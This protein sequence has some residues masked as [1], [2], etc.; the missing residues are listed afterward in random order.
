ML[1][2]HIRNAN[3]TDASIL[4]D[5]IRLSFI[6]VAWRFGLTPDKCPKHPSNCTDAWIEN[7]FARGVT[8]YIFENENAAIGCVALE[9]AD[10]DLCY[11]ERLSVLPAKRRKGFGRAL[12]DHVIHQANL[13]GAKQIGIGIIADDTELKQWYQKIGFV[14]GDTKE[15]EHLPFRVQFMHYQL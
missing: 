11:L 13:T 4:S 12:V 8:Y 5:L 10:S 1:N 2:N 15:F 9:K 6:G 3:L 7:D 14:A